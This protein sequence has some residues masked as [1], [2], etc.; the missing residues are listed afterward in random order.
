M[1]VFIYLNDNSVK[2][3]EHAKSIEYN[4]EDNVTVI[5]HKYGGSVINNYT[6]KRIKVCK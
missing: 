1:T 5:E 3:I 6:V 2:M 4:M